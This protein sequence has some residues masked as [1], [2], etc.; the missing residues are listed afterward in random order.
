M[1]HATR[2]LQS[3]VLSGEGINSGSHTFSWSHKDMQ[4]LLG[5]GINSMPGPPPR[6]HEHVRRYTAVIHPFILTRRIWKYDYDGQMI[7]EEL[8]VPKTSWYLFYRRGKT[9]KK[10]LTQKTFRPAIEAGPAAWEAHMLPPAPQ[11]WTIFPL[12][13]LKI[14]CLWSTQVI[15]GKFDW[16]GMELS[17]IR[18]KSKHFTFYYRVTFGVKEILQSSKNSTSII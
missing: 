16:N 5:L 13:S 4:G 10:N 9:S 8:C 2:A 14:Y 3:H 17:T 18:K 6:Q 12:H 7:F 15:F 1:P 11:W